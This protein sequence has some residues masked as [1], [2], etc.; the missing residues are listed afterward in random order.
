MVEDLTVRDVMTHEYVGVSESDTVRDAAELMLDESESI[1][2]V[3]RGS[4]PVGMVRER[5]LLAALLTDQDPTDTR[6]DA[7]MQ[8]PPRAL[9]SAQ[10]I[11]EAAIVLADADTAHVFVSEAGELVGVLSENDL[12]TAVTS[13]LATERSVP[14]E[15]PRAAEQ[16]I[17]TGG[18]SMTTQSVCEECGTLKADLE[19][20]NGQLICSDCRTI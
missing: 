10:T 7:V 9:E 2:A 3:L 5:E 20:V 1:I 18:G 4:E 6:I 17:E 13:M 14:E 16:L 11:G 15:T 8:R 19:H 12:I